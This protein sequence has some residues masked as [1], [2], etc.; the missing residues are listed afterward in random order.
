MGFS[1][2]DQGR[3]A[4]VR[5]AAATLLPY[6][7]CRKPIGVIAAAVRGCEG[8]V[9]Y[10][11]ANGGKRGGE[12]RVGGGGFVFFFF[13]SFHFFLFVVWA[14]EFIFIFSR[15]LQIADFLSLNASPVFRL[16]VAIF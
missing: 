3:S 5:E 15:A 9:T 16:I 12:G 13:C 6:S 2:R 7:C 11:N 14:T 8:R 1:G 10:K 4:A